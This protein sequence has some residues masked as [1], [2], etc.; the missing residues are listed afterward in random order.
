MML[1]F[2]AS[3]MLAPLMGGAVISAGFG[4]RGVFSTA[5][6]MVFCCGV[7]MVLDRLRLALWDR[8]EAKKQ[9]SHNVENPS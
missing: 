5:A 6:L 4:Y 3:G 2:D 9:S 7:F 1:T 8:R